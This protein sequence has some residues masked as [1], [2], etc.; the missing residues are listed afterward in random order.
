M[1]SSSLKLPACTR[2]LE[3]LTMNFNGRPFFFFRGFF[4]AR[5]NQRIWSLALGHASRY[6]KK[7]EKKQREKTNKTKNK[8]AKAILVG[9]GRLAAQKREL[10]KLKTQDAKSNA[11]RFPSRMT[12]QPL[13]RRRI[14][15]E[16][17]SVFPFPRNIHRR[18]SNI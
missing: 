15:Q 8:K 10:Q 18:I 9:R 17:A 4:V 7:R 14:V 5:A 2:N 3:R 13:T 6:D 1:W 16:P 11:E 12:R